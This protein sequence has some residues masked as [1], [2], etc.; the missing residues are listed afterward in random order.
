M[1][2]FV[3]SLQLLKVLICAVE[4]R[5]LGVAL[6]KVMDTGHG[7]FWVLMEFKAIGNV[8]DPEVDSK[9]CPPWPE[10]AHW[11]PWQWHPKM[12]SFLIQLPEPDGSQQATCEDGKLRKEYCSYL[13]TL[14]NSK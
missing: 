8:V 14:I 13:N 6:A 3:L 12:L 2:S 11:L 9:P 4:N 5:G 7:C 1:S 10:A